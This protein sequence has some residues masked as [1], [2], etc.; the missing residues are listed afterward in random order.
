MKKFAAFL[1]CLVLVLALCS[2]NN[3]GLLEG[4]EVVYD[5]VSDTS[6]GADTSSQET[7]GGDAQA[8]DQGLNASLKGDTSSIPDLDALYATAADIYGDLVN[9]T[10]SYDNALGDYEF[11]VNGSTAN[12]YRVND[13]RFFTKTELEEY[14]DTLFTEKCQKTFYQPDR[15]LDRSGKLY[16]IVGSSGE[17]PKYAG[18]S[19]KLTKQ[20]NKRIFLEG[21]GYYH[22][23]FDTVDTSK[24][25]FKKA[26]SDSSIYNT[27]K[28]EFVLLLSDNGNW[29]FDQFGFIG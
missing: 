12:Y 22:K 17:N 4:E 29:L 25:I 23:S 11:T 28:V 14:L 10:F 16:A 21:T 9:Y 5:S 7:V 19:L 1:L 2:C 8:T 27:V 15:F 6:E 26:P 24:P 13:E 18:Y 3:Q 20:T